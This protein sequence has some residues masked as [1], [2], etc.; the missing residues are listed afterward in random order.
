MAGVSQYF[1]DIAE[2]VPD[3]KW[4]DLAHQLGLKR[5]K[6]SAI[7]AE[8]RYLKEKTMK[9][10]DT[11][12][13]KN[14]RSATE[15]WLRMA[16]HD[17]DVG[18]IADHV[19]DG[20]PDEVEPPWKS[21]VQEE[22]RQQTST[23]CTSSHDVSYSNTTLALTEAK[24]ALLGIEGDMNQ[25]QIHD[26]HRTPLEQPTSS[27]STCGGDNRSPQ[28]GVTTGLLSSSGQ[29]FHKQGPTVYPMMTSPRGHALIVNNSIFDGN[30]S[31]RK[32]ADVDVK[33]VFSLLKSLGFTVKQL[34]NKS[35]QEML[36]ELEHFSK[37]DDHKN[38]SCCIVFLMSHGQEGCI[39]GKDGK[40]VMLKEIFSLFDN[41]HCQKLQGKPKLF[42]I[43]SCRGAKVDRGTV[44]PR[45]A[46]DAAGGLNEQSLPSQ[47]FGTLQGG[48]DVPD[49]ARCV[50]QPTRTDMFFGYATQEG[51]MAFR[52][53]TQGSWYI[54]A[55]DK[56][57][58]QHAADTHVAD[59]M[60][61][62]NKMVAEQTAHCENSNYTGGKEAS[63]FLSNLQKNLYFFPGL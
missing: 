32:G 29:F 61:M 16:L 57:F 12:R 22:G 20:V 54:Q 59:M 45:D 42:F 38:V 31:D 41:I 11:W 47:L 26:R 19:I 1:Y 28:G 58:R 25:L 55:I 36:K 50:D 40:T 46:P 21:G 33:T 53:E 5:A 14:G 34:L 2:E 18:W 3:D 24:G 39:I 17:A 63:E 37:L 15:A 48:E 23:C 51:N 13:L 4:K 8:N 30:L 49:A 44:S 56:V 7:D 43:Q 62:V 6:V 9:T 35:A 60:T 27:Q 10:L 52:N